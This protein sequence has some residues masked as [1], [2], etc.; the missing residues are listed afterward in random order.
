MKD[1]LQSS[2]PLHCC[3]PGAGMGGQEQG[4]STFRRESSGDFP[5]SGHM[6]GDRAVEENKQGRELRGAVARLGS[7]QDPRRGGGEGDYL[8]GC[9]VHQPMQRP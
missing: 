6:D 3:I 4:T 8:Q 7:S 2:A 9:L 5:Y 1:R